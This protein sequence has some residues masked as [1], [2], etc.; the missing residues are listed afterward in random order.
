MIKKF[1]LEGGQA[2]A[3]LPLS[4]PLITHNDARGAATGYPASRQLVPSGLH[5]IN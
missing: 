2:P 1:I 4:P 5:G 3:G